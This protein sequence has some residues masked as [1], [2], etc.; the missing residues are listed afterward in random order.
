MPAR[1]L[2]IHEVSLANLFAQVAHSHRISACV[3]VLMRG[4]RGELTSNA[5]RWAEFKSTGSH[6]DRHQEFCVYTA[7]AC[8]CATLCYMFLS[9]PALLVISCNSGENR[10]QIGRGGRDKTFSFAAH[11]S[12]P[13]TVETISRAVT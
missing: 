7:N 5:Q 10:F 6:Q 8:K 4:D 11:A 3:L 13:G 2:N 1:L 9:D 12:V